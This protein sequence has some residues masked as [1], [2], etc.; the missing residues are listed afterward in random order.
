M[1]CNE[2]DT[3]STLRRC[4]TLWGGQ[5][6]VL[7]TRKFVYLTLCCTRKHISCIKDILDMFI[8]GQED[9]F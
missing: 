9:I 3:I 4:I 1:S 2:R 7:G 8:I 5:L 6:I